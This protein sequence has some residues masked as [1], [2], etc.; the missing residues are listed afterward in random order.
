MPNPKPSISEWGY[1]EL[2]PQFCS[3]ETYY[4]EIKP[5]RIKLLRRLYLDSCPQ[6]II[7]YGKKYWPEYQQLFTNVRFNKRGQFMVGREGDTVI[8]FTDHFTARTMN[9]KLEEVVSLIS[10]IRD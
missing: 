1:E 9:G 6:A 8:I 4:K 7:A 10:T 3:R 2:I 5:Q